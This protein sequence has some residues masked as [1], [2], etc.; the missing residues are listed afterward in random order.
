MSSLWS[1]GL[2]GGIM[3]RVPLAPA[4]C[5]TQPGLNTGAPQGG[6]PHATN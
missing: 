3:L 4:G 2:P 1:A 6:Q 5:E